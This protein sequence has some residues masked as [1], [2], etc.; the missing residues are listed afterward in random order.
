MKNFPNAYARWE[1]EVYYMKK[2]KISSFKCNAM[3]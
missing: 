3:S 1:M 2:H